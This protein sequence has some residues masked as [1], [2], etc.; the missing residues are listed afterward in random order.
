MTTKQ[1]EDEG[2]N[3]VVW[4][5]VEWLINLPPSSYWGD[6]AKVTPAEMY[7]L[8]IKKGAT[9]ENFLNWISL[10]YEDKLLDALSDSMESLKLAEPPAIPEDLQ[11]WGKWEEEVPE[12]VIDQ[13]K[14]GSKEY[15]YTLSQT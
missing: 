8:T 13:G 10:R 9:K 4:E 12:R 2:I 7:D 15:P 14:E 3:Q 6:L 11:D 1:V 5:K